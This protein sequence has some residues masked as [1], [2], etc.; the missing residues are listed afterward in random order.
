[1]WRMH[2]IIGQSRY[3]R[4]SYI[5]ALFGDRVNKGRLF[6]VAWRLT[7]D[8]IWRRSNISYLDAIVPGHYVN[9]WDERFEHHCP[10]GSVLQGFQ[11]YHD[12]HKEDRRWKGQCRRVD[13]IT[14]YQWKSDSDSVWPYCGY[15]DCH[16]Y[17]ALYDSTYLTKNSWD[18]R[19]YFYF[20]GGA[21]ALTGFG[22]VHNN[23]KEDRKWWFYMAKV[24]KAA[25][26]CSWTGYV[27]GWDAAMNWYTSSNQWI[28][29][30]DS[31]H[32][33]YREDRRWK[34]Y[35]CNP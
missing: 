28:A 30:V 14:S 13:W 22:G 2:S 4:Y 24:T 20:T 31:Y 27:N 16:H 21:Y 5:N 17:S 8:R 12:N 26:S 11:S 1:M 29:G 23:Y 6:D 18:G 35:V 19:L 7:M 32:S 15:Y 9:A 34:F 3:G 25:S 33:N 10:I